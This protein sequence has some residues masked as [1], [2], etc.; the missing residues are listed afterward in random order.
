MCLSTLIVRFGNVCL[1]LRFRVFVHQFFSLIWRCAWYLYIWLDFL[2]IVS[3]LDFGKHGCIFGNL[4]LFLVI[5][6]NHCHQ[7]ELMPRLR[8]KSMGTDI[9]VE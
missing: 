3:S 9:Y 1:E 2:V 5:E 6:R 7:V 4:V 8:N